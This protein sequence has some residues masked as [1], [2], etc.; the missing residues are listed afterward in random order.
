MA[1]RSKDVSA[2]YELLYNPN[3][4]PR[5]S[6]DAHVESLTIEGRP[7]FILMKESDH[8]NYEVDEDT[9][10]VWGLLDGNRTVKEVIEAAAMADE[11]LTERDVKDVI[12]SLAEEGAI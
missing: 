4:I 6:P 12:A 9:S 3:F 2:I 8:E 5:R 10:K 7:A 11:S 1:I